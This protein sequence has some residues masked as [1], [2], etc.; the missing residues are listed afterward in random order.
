MAVFVVKGKKGT[1]TAPRDLPA[2]TVGS[3]SSCALSL[4]DPLLAETHCVFG[5][6]GTSY[7]V[8]DSGTSTGTYVDGVAVK[9]RAAIK[10]GAEVVVGVTRLL[11]SLPAD[12]PEL[13]LT[14]KEQ[15]FFFDKK[16][17]PL[18]WAREEIGFG[19]FRPLRVA[20]LAT[21]AVLLVSLPFCFFGPTH[22]AVMDLGP[23]ADVH[24]A[25]HG[26]F[27]SEAA[28]LG[29]EASDCDVCHDPYR[30]ATANKCAECHRDIVDAARHPFQGDPKAWEGGCATCHVDH[31]GGDSRV[32]RGAMKEGGCRDC[33]TNEIQA[34]VDSCATDASALSAI[35]AKR[36]IVPVGVFDVKVAY[37]TFSH[38]DHV[39]KGVACADCHFRA[40][41]P[42]AGSADA[43]RREFAR[44]TFEACSKCHAPDAASPKAPKDAAGLAHKRFSVDWHGT[45]D[46][47]GKCL[48]CHESVGAEALRTS[49]VVDVASRFRIGASR[50]HA[51]EIAAH[52]GGAEDCA[53]CHLN[54]AP[55][56]RVLEDRP[57]RHG[58][59]AK[60]LGLGDGSDKAR[61]SAACAEC[62]ADMRD[63]TTLAATLRDGAYHGP[64][65]AACGSCHGV[66]ASAPTP[67]LALRSGGSTVAPRRRVEFPHGLH[68]SDKARGRASLAEGC[69]SCHAFAHEGGDVFAATTS[70][71]PGA[72][73][74]RDCHETHRDIGG[75]ACADCHQ[76][77]DPAYGGVAVHK[78]WPKPSGFSHFSSGH[79]GP[80]GSDCR[81]CHRD[82]AS[83][84][85]AATLRAVRIPDESS[86]SCRACHVREGS[87][88][89]WR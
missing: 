83:V 86:P 19:R 88:F 54:G 76:R 25:S 22:A 34:R 11:C 29:V 66:G 85:E 5:H 35:L 65:A 44:V 9:G 73:D 18:H 55:K 59:H 21:I 10:D 17:D 12:K 13:T 36:A 46:G 79:V 87:R 51:D 50:A 20:T 23:L 53:S 6:D 26:R 43:P 4:E 77:G 62:H 39:Q 30:G 48:Q 31:Q 8:E 58:T 7:F 60:D 78:P 38:R 56:S 57:F 84:D 67:V 82:D 28:R 81:A 15:G 16:Q 24:R 74:C 89:H 68:L 49:E 64:D 47:G 80:T 33:H 45:D 71:K 37:D 1:P 41:A 61:A 52:K 27:A 32:L 40:E 14:V 63:A 75:G 3:R 42:I 70:T 69:F 72:S 2:L